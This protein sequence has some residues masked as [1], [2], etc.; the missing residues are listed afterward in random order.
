MATPK[1]H[2]TIVALETFWTPM[3]KF[4][5]PPG[6]TFTLIEHTRS[7][8]AEAAER[9][10]SATIVVTTIVPLN[11]DA[12]SEANCPDL[13][14]IALMA[15]GSDCLDLPTCRRRGITVSNCK[16]ANVAAVSEH[17]LSMCFAARRMFGPAQRGLRS[18]AWP[19]GGMQGVH[20]MFN[21]TDGYG[22]PSWEEEVLGL[23]G[24][25]PIGM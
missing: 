22:P 18:N 21:D 16:G 4:E 14:F 9:I 25:G 3:P 19:D 8:A 6:Y 15:S 12:L 23:V 7:T 13:Q 5:L 10:R 20:G 11:A 2:H 24:Y 1:K 17:A